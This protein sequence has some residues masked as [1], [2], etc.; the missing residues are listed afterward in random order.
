[1]YNKEVPKMDIFE[2]A[3]ERRK[4]QAAVGLKLTQPKKKMGRPSRADAL[5]RQRSA[6]RTPI[7][8]DRSI[9]EV[10][11]K[12]AGFQYR[13]VRDTSETGHEIV[14]YLSAGYEFVNRNKEGIVIGDNS[15][16]QSKAVGSIIRVPAGR[17]DDYL[18]LMKIPQEWYDEDQE[19]KQRE[20]DR[21]EE[22]IVNPEIEGKYGS[23]KIT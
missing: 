15:V 3:Q 19:A 21:R 20:V 1:M 13:W 9:L 4:Q 6:I 14:R 8:G 12:R 16:Y 23:I 22:A 2:Q 7:T 17:D 18:Y 10:H 11:G 5:A